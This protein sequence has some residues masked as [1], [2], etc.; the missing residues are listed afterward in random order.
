MIAENESRDNEILTMNIGH[1]GRIWKHFL[2]EKM[3]IVGEYKSYIRILPQ[4]Y[5]TVSILLL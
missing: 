1:S 5:F 2:T 4:Y 3:W